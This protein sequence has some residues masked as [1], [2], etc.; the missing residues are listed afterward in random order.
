MPRVCVLI[1]LC[2]QLQV[3]A[4]LLSAPLSSG[5]DGEAVGWPF[6]A[7]DLNPAVVKV[8]SDIHGIM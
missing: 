3:L 6:V 2:L 8:G 1:S 5:G 7:F 4:N